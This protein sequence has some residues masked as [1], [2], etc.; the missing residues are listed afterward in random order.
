MCH[1]IFC[2][3]TSSLS[4]IAINDDNDNG[5]NNDDGNNIF[6]YFDINTCHF[7]P[8][9]L[10]GLFFQIQ[11]I[12]IV[13]VYSTESS[14]DDMTPATPQTAII[15]TTTAAMMTAAT[16]TTTATTTT[17]AMTTADS[18][19]GEQS[20]ESGALCTFTFGMV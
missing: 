9:E 6:K 12:I 4:D 11:C 7:D 8:Y 5:N 2:Y 1:F 3:S 19:M 14:D 20:V 18:T 17:A 10:Y 13:V 16:T 15:T